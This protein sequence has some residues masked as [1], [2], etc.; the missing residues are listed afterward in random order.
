MGIRRGIGQFRRRIS[1]FVACR[2]PSPAASL[3]SLHD[4]RTGIAMTAFSFVTRHVFAWCVFYL[5]VLLMWTSFGL[6]EFPVVLLWMITLAFVIP[7][8]ISHIHRVGMIVGQKPTAEQ[9]RNRQRRQ[10]EVPF[11]AD[12]GFALVD[13]ALRELPDK[14]LASSVPSTL[15]RYR[16][17]PIVRRSASVTS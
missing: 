4:H 11:P 16:R 8:V 5:V 14:P 9:L 3:S 6:P 1:A 15:V 7:D 2:F 13:A 10:V 17:P 12:E